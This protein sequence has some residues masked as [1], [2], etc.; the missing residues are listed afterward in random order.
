MYFYLLLVTLAL[1]SARPDIG[2]DLQSRHSGGQFTGNYGGSVDTYL[3]IPDPNYGGA[4]YRESGFL[5]YRTNVGQ[6]GVIKIK[7]PVIKQGEPIV[8]KN[9]F[10]HTAG[11]DSGPKIEYEDVE[12]NVNPRVHYNILFVKA[13][14]AEGGKIN[15]TNVNVAPESKEKTIVYVLAGDN[16]PFDVSSSGDIALP[17]PAEPSKPELVYVRYNN[18]GDIKGAIEKITS[19]FNEQHR[20]NV[21]DFAVLGQAEKR[22]YDSKGLNPPRKDAGGSQSSSQASTQSSSQASSQASSQGRVLS[23]SQSSSLASSQT[24]AQSSSQTSSQTNSQSSGQDNNNFSSQ[25][26]LL[27]RSS[28]SAEESGGASVE[29][30]NSI[31]IDAGTQQSVIS[32]N[33]GESESRFVSQSGGSS[34]GSSNSFNAATGSQQVVQISSNKAGSSGSSSSQGGV[35]GLNKA[36]I[37]FV[38]YSSGGDID[39]II[40]K[41]KEFYNRQ[42]N[43]G[44]ELEILGQGQVGS[45]ADL[46]KLNLVRKRQI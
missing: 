6:G 34:S 11:S 24:S 41:I 28:E 8:T 33:G 19:S 39:G 7:R 1:V 27:A 16:G 46:A 45:Y 13:P 30:I 35:T 23:G 29:V 42:D 20:N 44:Q 22:G 3:P 43:S 14:T 36:G 5:D 12:Y 10:V 15:L 26:D 17:S 31:S 40:E 2:L 4:L 25:I 21:Q 37:Q 18:E 9:F 32:A 38:K